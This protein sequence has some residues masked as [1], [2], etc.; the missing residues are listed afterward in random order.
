MLV[1]VREPDKPTQ[2]LTVKGKCTVA[3]RLRAT[4]RRGH[5][6][7]AAGAV[8]VRVALLVTVSHG[9]TATRAAIACTFEEWRAHWRVF[10]DELG[11]VPAKHIEARWVEYATAHGVPSLCPEPPATA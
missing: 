4:T 7:G 11:A 6:V 1:G 2:I 10:R 8:P 3:V 5:A 9:T